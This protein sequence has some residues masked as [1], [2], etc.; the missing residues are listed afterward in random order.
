MIT[1]ELI[2]DAQPKTHNFDNYK[3]RCSSL[4]YLM[5][6]PRS[7]SEVISETT[8]THLMDC[9]VAAVFNRRSDIQSKFL[10]KGN[11]VEENSIDLYSAYK[12]D[13]FKKND[14][15]LS[16]EYIS[17]T[18]DLL[19]EEEDEPIIVDL[20]SS[21]DIYTF[22][23][24]MKS[25][26][27]MYYWQVQGYM[28]LTGVKRARVAYC[29]VDT[30]D[31]IIDRELRKALYQSGLPESSEEFVNYCEELRAFYKYSDIPQSKRVFE[32][33]YQYSEEDIERLYQRIVDCRRY[34][35]EINW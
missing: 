10:E 30:P 17:G 2:I 14:Q 22:A 11:L 13:F 20:K 21:W 23:R 35:N 18:Y 12:A 27:K 1:Q 6:D 5:T 15:R 33:E 28:A 4:G 24:S 7:K 19:I 29:L 8:K 25:E 3:F 9:Y 31:P 16:N 32:R 26:N 34:L